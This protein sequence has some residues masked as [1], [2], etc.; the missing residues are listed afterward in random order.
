MRRFQYK[1]LC[2]VLYLTKK[3]F[4][5]NKI[6]S[7]EYPFCKFQEETTIHLFY[8]CWKTKTLWSQLISHLNDTFNLSH[9]TARSAIL[10]FLDISGIKDYSI[11]NHLLLLFKYYIY[12][13]RLP[14]ASGL[15]SF[16]EKYKKNIWYWEKFTW[17]GS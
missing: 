2:N 7:P 4:Q 6:S 8:T 16:N 1:I 13:A 17:P 9:L 15:W 11:I 3:L 10:G 12:N 14:K 5:F